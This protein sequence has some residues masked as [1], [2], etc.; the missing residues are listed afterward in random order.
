MAENFGEIITN[1]STNGIL[2]PN[3]VAQN[4]PPAPT[5]SNWYGNGTNMSSGKQIV[6][7]YK[8]PFSMGIKQANASKTFGQFVSQRTMPSHSGKTF[9]INVF[10]NIYDRMPW[11][12]NTWNDETVKKVWSDNFA[13]YGF[14]SSRDIAEASSTLYGAAGSD[15]PAVNNG[16]NGIRIIEGQLSGNKISPR[17]SAIEAKLER[18][19]EMIDYTDELA[20]FGEP[21]MI[22]WYH[23]Q[24]GEC[25]NHRR[26]DLHQYHML[27]TPN[28]MFSGAASTMAELGAGIGTGAVDTITKRN[29]VEEDYKIN[30]TLIQKIKQKLVRYRVPQHKSI[31]AAGSGQKTQPIQAS[32]VAIVGPEI[33]NDLENVTRGATVYTEDFAF[34]PVSQYAS[35]QSVM[36]NEIGQINGIRFVYAERMFCYRGQGAAVDAGYTGKL[37]YTGTLGTDAKFDVFPI[38]IPGADSFATISLNG[39]NGAVEFF[40]KSPSQNDSIDIFGSIGYYSYKMYYA[41]LITRPERLLRVNVLAQG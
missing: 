29:A 27:S 19:G 23:Q 38:L 39:K 18:F 4:T 13:K 17:F 20:T 5:V 22:I 10:Y 7:F 30:Y 15:T 32:W 6:N 25:V 3:T 24:L 36:D 1:T 33:K 21:G 40:S 34:V 2:F 9:K 11:T 28:Q 16:A 35:Q 31:I 14:L 8:V 41:G 37:S 26:E 12:D